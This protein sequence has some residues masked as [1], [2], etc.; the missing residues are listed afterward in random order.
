MVAIFL[1]RPSIGFPMILVEIFADAKAG[2]FILKNRPA[3]SK[4]VSIGF[5]FFL[6][7]FTFYLIANKTSKIISSITR[8]I[9]VVSFLKKIAKPCTPLLV[10][11][12]YQK[13]G[14]QLL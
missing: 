11:S 6:N 12:T 2:I 13:S 7:V 9:V 5:M 1:Y 3:K 8:L 4:N 10:F 14:V